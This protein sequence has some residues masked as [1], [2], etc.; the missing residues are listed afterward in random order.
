MKDLRLALSF[1]AAVIPTSTEKSYIIK[2]QQNFP[3]VVIF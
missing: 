3:A 2:L 1:A